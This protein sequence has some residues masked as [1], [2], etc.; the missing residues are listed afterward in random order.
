[1]RSAQAFQF[2]PGAHKLAQP[3]ERSVL[4]RPAEKREDKHW[5][6]QDEDRE[7]KAAK[8]ERSKEQAAP[9]PV[10]VFL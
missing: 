4:V 9:E 1:M 3:Q 5:A 7:G 8:S 10:V 2:S 6:H